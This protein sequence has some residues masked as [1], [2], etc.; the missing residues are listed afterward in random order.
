VRADVAAPSPLATLFDLLD[1]AEPAPEIG[2]ELPPLAHWLYFSSWGRSSETGENGDYLDPTLPPIELPRRLCIESRIQFHHPI[3]V[4][5]PISRLTRVVDVA[6]RAGRAGPIVTLLLRNEIIDAEDVAVSEERRLL[7]MTRGEAWHSSEPR[8]A[9]QSAE[10][11]RQFRPDTRALFRYSALTRNMSRVHYDRPFALFVEGH[12]GLVV[13]NELVT[14]RLFD[15]L[16]EHRPGAR[17][18]SCEL[19]TRRWLYDTEPTLLFGRQRDDGLVELW[20][21]DAQG[22]LAIEGVV[23]LDRDLS[24]VPGVDCAVSRDSGVLEPLS[25][26]P[27]RSG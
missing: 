24:A 9:R 20:A 2:A 18:R 6:E 3:H 15:L 17:V 7:Y 13:Q 25:Q 8:R 22:R 27:S 14:A 1:L 23:T 21:E 11:S 4:G 26:R 10:W 16:R 5:D 12:P 19:R